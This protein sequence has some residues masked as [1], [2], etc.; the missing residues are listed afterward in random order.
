MKV[1]ILDDNIDVALSVSQMTKACLPEAEILVFYDSLEA[2]RKMTGDIDIFITDF[3]MPGLD[4]VAMAV[5]AKTMNKKTA[6][7]MISGL[8]QTEIEDTPRRTEDF[9]SSVDWF[10]AKPVN[11][12]DLQRTIGEIVE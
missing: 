6:V 9:R 2:L 12:A 10:I 8:P 1:L 3:D 7:V 4:G 5:N 11:L